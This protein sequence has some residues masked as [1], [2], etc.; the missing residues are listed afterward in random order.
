MQ[1]DFKWPKPL[2]HRYGAGTRLEGI[3]LFYDFPWLDQFPDNRAQFQNGQC[4]AHQVREDC[5]EGK[6]PAL[7]LTTRRDAE[8]ECFESE[9]FF[10]MVINLPAY[11]KLASANAAVSYLAR[12]FGGGI[13]KI[14]QLTELADLSPA[15]IEDF[16]HE[17]MSAK[18]I[19]AWAASDPVRLAALREIAGAKEA[20]KEAPAASA[21]AALQALESFDE[22]VVEALAAL[23]TPEMDRDSR[24]VLLRTL[25]E[26]P[27]GRRDAGEVLS[28]RVELR[29]GDARRASAEFSA[30]LE[31]PGT[32]ETKLQRFIEENPWLLGLHYARIRPRHPL[33]RG[34]LDFILER[35]DGFH[36]LLELKAPS[37]PIIEAPSED[38]PPPANKYKLSTSL[39]RAIAQVHVY[40][41]V[42]SEYATA[43][44]ELYGLPESRDPRIMIVIGRADSMS[45]DRARVLR[46]FNRSLH[47]VEIVPYDLLARRAEAI[48]DSVEKYLVVGD[49]G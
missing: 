12:K 13:T 38:P 41:H 24:L 20:S 44:E 43:S 35:Y 46:E 18:R 31:D 21:V 48:L 7:L 3:N 28:E 9:R 32:T 39:S 25:T 19:R 30:L 15:E 29:L 2:S 36:D 5:P 10:V 45:A 8:E 23:I 37:D 42:L 6:T 40:R 11:R 34:Q 26:D 47:R 4:L 17:Q 1:P 22:E 27:G 49:S 33:P 14:G 16:V